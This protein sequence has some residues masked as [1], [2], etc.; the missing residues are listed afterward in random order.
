MPA[1]YTIPDFGPADLLTS[2]R[3]GTRRI[4]VDVGQTGFFEGR[5]FRFVRK[6]TSPVVYKFVAPVEF[7]L[8]FQ[9]FGITDGEFEFYAWRG[10]N[11]TEN[12]PFNTELPAFGKNTSTTRPLFNGAYYQRQCQIF[13]GGTITPTDANLYADYEHLKTASASGQRVSVE[14][15]GREERYLAAGT[16]YLQFSGTAQALFRL[17]WE[18]RPL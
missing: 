14:G 6:L 12:T 18:E 17:T 11:I 8:S 16:Y 3:E 9:G 5:E 4:R 7:I 13:S 10:D 15:S 2:Q 1:T